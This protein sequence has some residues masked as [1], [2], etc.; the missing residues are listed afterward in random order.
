MDYVIVTDADGSHHAT[1]G[2]FAMSVLPEHR[3]A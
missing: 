3:G 1:N 2:M